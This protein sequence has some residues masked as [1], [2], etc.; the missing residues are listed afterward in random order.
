[1]LQNTIP[2]TTPPAVFWRWRGESVRG[3]EEA[4]DHLP[5][6]VKGLNILQLSKKG[7]FWPRSWST[8]MSKWTTVTHRLSSPQSSQRKLDNFDSSVIDLLHDCNWCMVY[9]RQGPYYWC[10]FSLMKYL[11]NLIDVELCYQKSSIFIFKHL[12]FRLECNI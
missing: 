7:P 1:M 12:K 5:W 2:Q 11:F 8:S 10:R 9:F 3:K 4:R 6:M